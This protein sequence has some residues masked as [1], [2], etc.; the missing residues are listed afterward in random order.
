M[1]KKEYKGCFKGIKKLPERCSTALKIMLKKANG[2]EKIF[3]NLMEEKL[4][5]YCGDHV[6]CKNQNHCKD[7]ISI[8]DEAA[9]NEFK[10]CKVIF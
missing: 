6:K 3:T 1:K 2:D 7:V 10:V 9:Q 4:A 8:Q 5:H